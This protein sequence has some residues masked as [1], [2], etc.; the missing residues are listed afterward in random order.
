MESTEKSPLALLCRQVCVVCRR[1]SC[2][3]RTSR[4][5]WS[6]RANAVS[7][8]V[9]EKACCVPPFP[10]TTQP[11]LVLLLPN[12][13][14]VPRFAD[15]DLR[16]TAVL[17]VP[18]IWHRNCRRRAACCPSYALAACLCSAH[19][20]VHPVPER[21]TWRGHHARQG[22]FLHCAF[23][24]SR[25]TLALSAA[26]CFPCLRIG[27][28]CAGSCCRRCTVHSQPQLRERKLPGPVRSWLSLSASVCF[29][30]D[31]TIRHVN[32]YEFVGRL[33]GVAI[34]TNNPLSLDLPSLLWKPLV[35]LSVRLTPHLPSPALRLGLIALLLVS[36]SA[37]ISIWR[38]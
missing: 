36:R 26:F 6:T 9:R 34:R 32:R 22:E 37:W 35:R 3:R 24:A 18:L 23:P 30:G 15:T 7:T 14:S 17:Y 1:S 5:A 25:P 16:R 29:G 8:Q 10:S 27:L 33:M 13:W 2:A 20:A 21:E 38:T 31:N 28:M 4:G 19:P 11:A 12:R